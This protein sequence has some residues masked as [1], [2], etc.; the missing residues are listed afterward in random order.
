MRFFFFFTRLQYENE[1]SNSDMSRNFKT[2]IFLN[3]L[4]P[5]EQTKHLKMKTLL[6]SDSHPSSGA[7]DSLNCCSLHSQQYMLLKP[8]TLGL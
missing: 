2:E 4:T 8:Y 7:E 6:L 3:T 5:S 1:I